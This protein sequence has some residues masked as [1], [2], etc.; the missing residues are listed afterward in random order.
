MKIHRNQS[1]VYLQSYFQVAVFIVIELVIFPLGCGIMLDV[2]SVGLFPEANL[3][4][5]AVFF[6]QSPV[7]ALFY[8]WVAGTMFMYAFSLMHY[9]LHLIFPVYI[10]YQFAILLAGCRGIM[11]PGAM[12][13]IKDPQDQNFHPIRD[14]LERPT[15]TQLRKLMVSAVMYSFVVAFGVGSITGLLFAGFHSMLPLRWKTRWVFSRRPC[16]CIP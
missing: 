6:L 3:R 2:C 11:R 13:F 15:L 16:I 14:I 10:R 4:S 8:H 5:R 1:A 9:H 7:T 12:W